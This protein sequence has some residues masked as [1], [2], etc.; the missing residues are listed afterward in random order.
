MTESTS[1]QAR[2]QRTMRNT[3]WSLVSKGLG[4]MIR[5]AS[6]PLFL[7]YLG[8][9]SYGLL[10]LA[11]AF[12]GYLGI[13]SL[14]VPVGMVRHAAAWMS[15]GDF[16]KIEKA[17]QS[18]FSFFLGIG[19]LN[20]L[21]FAYVAFYGAHWFQV[22][23]ASLSDFQMVFLAAGVYSVISWPIS[24]VEQLLTAEEELVWLAKVSAFQEIT[25]L[26]VVLLGLLLD[27]DFHLFIMLYL[28]FS[29]VGLPLNLFKWFHLYPNLKCF[30]PSWNWPSFREVLSFS[31]GLFIIGLSMTSVT[32]LRPIL[33]A[34]RA[35]HSVEALADYQILFGLTGILLVFNG[36]LMSNLLPLATKALVEKNSAL[37]NTIL[38]KITRLA[39][40]IFAALIFGLIATSDRLLTVYIGPEKAYLAPSLNLWLGSFLYFYLAPIAGLVIGSGKIR[41]LAITSPVSASIGLL[42]VWYFAPS[43]DVQA[44]A[45]GTVI[46]LGLQFIVYHVYYIPHVL[47]ISSL[48]LLKNIFFPIC[49]GGVV[50]V[51]TARFFATLIAPQTPWLWLLIATCVGALVYSIWT[52]TFVMPLKE[53]TRYLRILRGGTQVEDLESK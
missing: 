53:L 51:F 6:I 15:T 1:N 50:M 24:L 45:L 30:R 8:E 27:L 35:Q 32:Q 42:A 43:I 41:L 22:P 46:Y 18:G 28:G 10:I 21:L 3:S 4:G 2:L 14:G 29:R 20:G 7:A 23:E 48:N 47:G 39:W 52:H 36:V 25:K 40:V 49:L 33:L 34:A 9:A 31:L 17:S 16:Y 11:L 37:I 5:L 26:L 44:C 13:A 38:F 19:I 12:S